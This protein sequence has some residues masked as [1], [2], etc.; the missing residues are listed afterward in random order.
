MAEHPVNVFDKAALEQVVLQV[1]EVITCALVDM[2]L[3]RRR[4]GEVCPILHA[5]R[6]PGAMTVGDVQQFEVYPPAV[7]I[8]RARTTSLSVCFI[9]RSRGGW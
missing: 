1:Y 3:S 8:T 5:H 9:T 4:K 7:V 6:A 2:Q